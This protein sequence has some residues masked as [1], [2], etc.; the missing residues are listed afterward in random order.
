MDNLTPPPTLNGDVPDQEGHCTNSQCTR[1]RGIL[2]GL[3]NT[4]RAEK[5]ALETENT[6]LRAEI[7][8]LRA[9]SSKHTQRVCII[10]D[11]LPTEKR[12]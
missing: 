1:D 10:K 3:N 8:R 11:N 9:R 2:E 7:A 4:L 12:D 5:A 6:E